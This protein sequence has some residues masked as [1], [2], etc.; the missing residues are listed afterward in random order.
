MLPC[1][2]S[3]PESAVVSLLAGLEAKGLLTCTQAYRHL[4]MKVGVRTEGPATYTGIP[5]PP[6]LNSN[7]TQCILLTTPFLQVQFKVEVSDVATA[8]K[9]DMR[10]SAVHSLMS[11]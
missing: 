6:L 11:S 5:Q 3:C 4:H 8:F 10:L 1:A 2:K 7:Y 9:E